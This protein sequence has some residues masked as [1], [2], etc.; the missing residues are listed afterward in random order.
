MRT[1]NEMY[2]YQR[3]DDMGTIVEQRIAIIGYSGSGKSTLAQKLGD[4]Y[5]CE[6]LH[7]DCVHWLPGWEERD[8]A[9]Q[10]KIVSEFMDTHDSWVMD[11]NYKSTCY[12]RR[13]REATQIIFLD[14]PVHLCL[15]RAIKRYISYR[16]KSRESMTEG[17]DEKFDKEFF[18]W[19]VHEGR[20]RAHRQGYKNVCKEYAE[21]IVV[22]KNPKEV[23]RFLGGLI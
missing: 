12:D 19:I 6:V 11:G 3:R 22:L 13:M 5:Q 16:G 2:N 8:S 1:E 10:N 17:C 9:G 14:F 23:R 15:Y 7:L 4:K 20:D 21:K 18:W